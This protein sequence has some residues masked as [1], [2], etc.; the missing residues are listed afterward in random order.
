M[1]T[2]PWQH[3]TGKHGIGACL[4]R[5]LQRDS[6]CACLRVRLILYEG[7]PMGTARHLCKGSRYS[8]RETPCAIDS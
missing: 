2:T 3:G 8:G 6:G 4:T 1:H 5:V 7:R